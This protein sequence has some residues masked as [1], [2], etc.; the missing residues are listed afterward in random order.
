MF[1]HFEKGIKDIKCSK[2]I[3]FPDLIKLIQNNPNAHKI[4]TIRNLRKNGDELYKSLKSELPNITPSCMVKLR[5][6]ED[7][8]F[9]Q[10]FIQF[11][12]YLYYDIDKWNAEEYK[13]YFINRY[14]HQASMICI[15]SSGGGISVLFKIKNTITKDNFSEIWQTV[16]DNLLSDEPIDNNSKGIGRAMFISNDPSVF[17]NYENELEVEV[18]NPIEGS[19]K[20]TGKQSKTCKDFINNLISPFSIISIDRVLQKITTHTIVPVANPIIDFRPVE[21]V[22]VYIPKIIKDGTVGFPEVGPIKIRV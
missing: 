9:D 12:Q 14:G 16:R 15:S 4:E 22:E 7:D 5:N 2:F 1:S 18:K 6:L 20:K 3:G 17:Y 10:N 8:Q 11:S 13:S 21:Y 19:Y